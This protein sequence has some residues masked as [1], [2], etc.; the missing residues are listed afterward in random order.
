MPSRCFCASRTWVTCRRAPRQRRPPE[1]TPARGPP[2][3]AWQRRGSTRAPAAWPPRLDTRARARAVPTCLHTRG[4]HTERSGAVKATGTPRCPACGGLAWSG[5]APPSRGRST[6][7]RARTRR[8][9]TRRRR[10]SPAPRSAPR[11]QASV[12]ARPAVR[13]CSAGRRAPASQGPASRRPSAALPGGA[14]VGLGPEGA[15]AR[16]CQQDPDAQQEHR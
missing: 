10:R 7:R 14:S 5:R 3:A 6:G 11:P 15:A 13:G 4:A 2:G 12:L 9:R 1:R 16:A 8:P